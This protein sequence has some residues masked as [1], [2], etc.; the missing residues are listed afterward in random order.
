MPLMLKNFITL[1]ITNRL[2][3]N[4]ESEVKNIMKTDDHIIWHQSVVKKEDRH[5]LNR[6]KSIMI[7]FTGLSGSGKSTLANALEQELY[8]R[9]VRSYLL[10]GDN[11]RHGLNRDLGFS[12]EDRKEN[13]R[14]LAEVGKLFVDAGIVVL[15]A[16]ISPFRKER[17]EVRQQFKP[18]EFIE[19][20][21]RCSLEECERRD[22]KQLYKK[23]RA[24]QIKQ[25]TGITQPYEPPSQPEIIID[26]EKLSLREAVQKLKQDIIKRL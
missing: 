16:T 6:H 26:T 5:S 24:G 19:V 7:W 1:M 10:D 23:A 18:G 11:V 12:D 8:K 25:F 3:L 4:V 2:E 13:M 15:A 14:R 21:V 17:F 20:Y 9:H 22:P